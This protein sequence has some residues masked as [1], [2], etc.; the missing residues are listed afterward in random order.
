MKVITNDVDV[1][2]SYHHA[3]FEQF[4]L[5]NLRE[6]PAFTDFVVAGCAPVKHQLFS[7]NIW[8][9]HVSERRK[10]CESRGSHPGPYCC[11]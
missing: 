2:G 4:Y 10:M 11:P 8:H 3:K 6:K 5:N 9:S 1:S 7:F